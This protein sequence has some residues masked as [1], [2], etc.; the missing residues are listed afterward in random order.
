MR[1]SFG[2]DER[3]H[4]TDFVAGELRRRGHDVAA[5]GPPAGEPLPWPDVARAVAALEAAG[6]APSID[7]R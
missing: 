2:S 3:T 5:H 6:E 4:V 7:V 1:I